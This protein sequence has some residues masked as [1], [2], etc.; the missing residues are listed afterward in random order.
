ML[1]VEL[2]HLPKDDR[3]SVIVDTS[4]VVMVPLNG[5]L[6]RSVEENMAGKGVAQESPDTLSALTAA[7]ICWLL[8]I[9]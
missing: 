5:G 1:K 9:V 4:E 7:G 8:R 6:S 2:E 3:R